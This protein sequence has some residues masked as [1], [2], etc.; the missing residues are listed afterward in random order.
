MRGEAH[1][2]TH[3]KTEA[4]QPGIVQEEGGHPNRFLPAERCAGQNGDLPR[5]PRPLD[6]Q[7]MAPGRG[8][9]SLWIGKTWRLDGA[10][11][12]KRVRAGTPRQVFCPAC[13]KIRDGYPSG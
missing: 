2:D 3:L 1:E 4:L 7:A 13:E 11:Y 9:P 6:R 5:M 8:C 10:A 12:A